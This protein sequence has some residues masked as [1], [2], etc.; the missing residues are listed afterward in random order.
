MPHHTNASPRP[1]GLGGALSFGQWPAAAMHLVALRTSP[2]DHSIGRAPS[3][4]RGTYRGATETRAAV[5]LCAACT[6]GSHHLRAVLVQIRCLS[7][8][9]RQRAVLAVFFR[10][11]RTAADP[12]RSNRS[13]KASA[14]GF[15]VCVG[16]RN[17]ARSLSDTSYQDRANRCIDAHRPVKSSS[18]VLTCGVTIR[19]S[20]PE[21]LTRPP[22]IQSR[23]ARTLRRRMPATRR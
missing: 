3:R 23:C 16:V 20:G 7:H 12:A 8:R 6:N 1:I 19:R 10:G 4:C 21:L 17:L 14:D 11:R 2:V 5:S 9:R 22:S 13:V 18:D 15:G